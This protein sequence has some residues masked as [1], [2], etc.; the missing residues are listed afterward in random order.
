MTT[1]LRPPFVSEENDPDL[2]IEDCVPCSGLMQYLGSGGSAPATLA[3]AEALRRDSGAP[4]FG[5]MSSAQLITG[6]TKRYGF[7]A[8]NALTPAAIIA[9]AKVGQSVTVSGHLSNF[10]VGHRLRR[11]SPDFRGGHRWYASIEDAGPW[12][13][14]PLGPSDGSY[15]GERI[16]QS[17]IDVFAQGGAGG[18]VAPL[19]K[20]TTGGGNQPGEDVDPLIDIPVTTATVQ[21]NTIVWAD[22]AG[23]TRL[24]VWKA[25]GKAGVYSTA[26]AGSSVPNMNHGPVAL[27]LDLG[28]TA[29]PNL[30]IGWVD[31]SR[32]TLP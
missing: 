31:K 23:T 13:M 8:T 3:E 17:E 12:L 5:P 16:T 26:A 18:T 30:V 2:L 4:A 1:W 7:A 10:P 9:A 19:A 20:V 24:F 22:R 27:R 21:A 14:D 29:A 6:T 32:V 11:F 25:G 15:A 28:T